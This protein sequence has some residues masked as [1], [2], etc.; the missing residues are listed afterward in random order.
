MDNDELV[1]S[2]KDPEAREGSVTDHPA[3]EISTGGRPRSVR[4]AVLL[5]GL[6][7]AAIAMAVPVGH[8][9]VTSVTSH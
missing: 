7:G 5:A 9:T 6:Y 4:R 1:R 3:G 8:M 2:W